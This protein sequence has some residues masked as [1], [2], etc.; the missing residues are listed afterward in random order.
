MAASRKGEGHRLVQVTEDQGWLTGCR[1]NSL[2]GDSEHTAGGGKLI[3]QA[4]LDWQHSARP[5]AFSTLP[6]ALFPNYSTAQGAE[7]TQHFGP[8][9]NRMK[10][11]DRRLS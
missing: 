8:G 9:Q 7:R 1:N 2:K 5:P 4:L 6:S 11:G 10:E 3:P